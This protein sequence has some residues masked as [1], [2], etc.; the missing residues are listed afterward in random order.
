MGFAKEM[1][2][3]VRIPTLAE[4]QRDALRRATCNIEEGLAHDAMKLFPGCSIMFWGELRLRKDEFT[5]LEGKRFGGYAGIDSKG[6][7]WYPYGINERIWVHWPN[8][9]E[10][11][12][13]SILSK[14]GLLDK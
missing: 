13:I 10:G 7:Q 3:G 12:V 9:P 6:R 14:T 2:K 11:K 8:L 4:N 5:D 1:C